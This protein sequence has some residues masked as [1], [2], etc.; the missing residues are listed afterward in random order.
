MLLACFLFISAFL[1]AQTKTDRVERN[2]A[3]PLVTK[4]YY[5]IYNNA[6]KLNSSNYR[7]TAENKG[8]ESIKPGSSV[9]V[10]PQKGYYSIGKNAERITTNQSLDLNSYSGI[11]QKE[12]PVINKGYYSI[13]TN[14]KK[15]HK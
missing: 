2:G 14:A 12:V 6:E 13:G 3:R 1:N 8:G 7:K 5:S 9:A 10:S 11:I 4:G 15:L